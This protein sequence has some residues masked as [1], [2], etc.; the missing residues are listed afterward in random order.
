MSLE[1]IYSIDVI[2]LHTI[3]FLWKVYKRDKNN[4]KE[5]KWNMELN[6]NTRNLSSGMY[7][8]TLYIDGKKVDT[9]KMIVE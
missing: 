3:S 6:I 8:Y 1:Y 9:K 7:Y 5:D 4:I 2:F